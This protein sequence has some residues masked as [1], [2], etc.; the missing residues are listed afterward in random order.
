MKQGTMGMASMM[1]L[2]V[3]WMDLAWE[4]MS[5]TMVWGTAFVLLMSIA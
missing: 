3:V 1:E 5:T 4:G 2:R